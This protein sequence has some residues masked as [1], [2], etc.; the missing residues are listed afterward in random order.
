LKKIL[1]P[2][3]PFPRRQYFAEKFFGFWKKFLGGGANFLFHPPNQK[4]LGTALCV[5]D[6]DVN[7]LARYGGANPLRHL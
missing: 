7:L 2:P 3:P 4:P 1:G 6:L 5:W